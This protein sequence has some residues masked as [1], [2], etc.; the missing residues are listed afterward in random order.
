MSFFIK[1]M[2]E[3]RKLAREALKAGRLT[4]EDRMI[5][6]PTGGIALFRQ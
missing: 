5:T 3:A 4:E 2:V 1:H 6:R